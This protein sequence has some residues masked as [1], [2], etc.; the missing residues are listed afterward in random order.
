[1]GKTS[2]GLC[3]RPEAEPDVATFVDSSI[4]SKTLTGAMPRDV[5]LYI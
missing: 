3:P 4:C 2:L 1:M 5:L